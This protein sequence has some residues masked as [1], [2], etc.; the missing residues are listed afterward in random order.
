MTIMFSRFAASPIGPSLVAED[1]GLSLATTDATSL[2]SAARSDLPHVDGVRGVEWTFWGEDDLQATVGLVTA[3]ASLSAQVGSAGGLGWRLHSGEVV[4]GGVVVASGLPAVAK[5][6]VVGLRVDLDA[7]TVAFYLAGDVVHSRSLALSGDLH[8]AVSLASTA[9]GGLRCIVNAGQ[10]QGF[11]PALAGWPVP[12]AEIEPLRLAT[13]PYMS[14]TGD[15]PANASYLELVAGDGIQSIAAVSFWP[16]ADGGSRGAAAQVKLQDA[17]GVLDDVALGDVRDVPV[18]VRLVQQGEALA[19]ATAVSRH[20]LERIDI[21]DDGRKTAVLRDPHDDLDAPLHRAVFLPSINDQVAWQPQPVVIGAVRSAPMVPVNSDGSVQWISDAPLA[22]VDRV[23]DRGAEILAGDG[24]TLVAGG[25]QLAFDATPVGPLIADVSSIGAGMAPA[26]LEQALTE[27][28][29]RINKAAWSSADAAAIDTATGYAGVGY[30]A[31]DGGTPRQALAALLASYTADWWQD[32]DGVLRIARLVDPDTLAEAFELD[33]TALDA[34]LVVQ[35]DLAPGLSR[36]MAYQPNAY[37]L[38]TGDMI[39]DLEQLPPAMRQQ[40]AGEYRG[41]VYA[42]GPLASR[43]VR[44]E[45]AAPMLSRFDRRAD[46][47]AEIDRVIALYAV[48]RNFYIGRVRGRT[49]LQFRPGQVIRIT[50][51]R[52]GLAAG[53]KVLVASAIGNP[54]TG[55]HTVKFWGA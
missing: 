34:D 46:A 45:A 1:G 50:Y 31:G 16:W 7:G 15:S 13:E 22:S 44:A 6:D 37:P 5:G 53:R 49:D 32:G 4:A 21:E 39:T 3:A 24:Y 33:W 43:Y 51:G 12:A 29:R 18:R 47:Q 35:P 48:P 23:L 36:R 28:F 10:W 55:E 40:L 20:I 11:A 30:Y 27:V 41:Q 52:Y 9:A 54:V 17:H 38:A 42:G 19:G 25:Q 26:T 8:F 2:A 14:A